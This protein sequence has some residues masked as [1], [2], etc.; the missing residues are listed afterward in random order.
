MEL[1][2]LYFKK[3][4]EKKVEYLPNVQ[5]IKCGLQIMPWCKSCQEGTYITFVLVYNWIEVLVP[6]VPP[7]SQISECYKHT[8]L[9][10][11]QQLLFP[12]RMEEW[13]NTQ[14]K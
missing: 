8:E 7:S 12:T 4:P 14:T 3:Q 2:K 11:P 5:G 10:H 6:V 1:N 13:I 9:K